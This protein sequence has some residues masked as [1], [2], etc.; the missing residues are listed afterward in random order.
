MSPDVVAF[1]MSQVARSA[2]LHPTVL[3]PSSGGTLTAMYDSMYGQ[4]WLSSSVAA[5]TTCSVAM[6]DISSVVTPDIC[7]T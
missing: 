1:M 7:R 4:I 3:P 2:V 6:S 5:R